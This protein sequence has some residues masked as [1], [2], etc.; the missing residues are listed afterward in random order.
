M[1]ASKRVASI[2]RAAELKRRVTPYLRVC[3]KIPTGFLLEKQYA[4]NRKRVLSVLG[5][6]E[7]NWRD[8]RWHMRNR[9]SDAET[10][11]GILNLTEG[12]RVAIDTVGA[13]YRWGVSPYY[14]SLMDGDD[15]NCPIR[16]Q[17]LPVM[18]E[19]TDADAAL[20]PMAEES[21]S[22]A[23]CVT[24]RYPD[25][26][27]INLTNRCA[28]FCRHCQRKRNIGCVDEA[29]PRKE[30]R[31]ALDYVRDNREIRDVLLTGGDPFT[32]D[33]G[34]LDWVLG[35]LDGIRHVE[36]KRIGTRTLCTLPM[37]TT[38]KLARMLGKHAPLYV[39]THFNHPK[40]VTRDAARAC[41]LLSREGVPLG[42]QAVLLK[43]V[44][45]DPYVMKK[46]C[47]ELLRIRVRPYYLYH[48]KN[49]PGAGKFRTSVSAG[50]RIISEMRGFTSGLAVP[51]F[52]INTP[53][54]LGKVALLPDGVAR[55]KGGKLILRTW[56]GRFVDYSV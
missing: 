44:N 56:E 15:A 33:D 7:R 20:D 29:K 46:L 54:G 53:G 34:E 32:L 21:S 27:I 8:W 10:L 28:M 48:C 24:R 37:R 36:I 2:R 25:R 12:E 47:Q 4:R 49:V 14:A 3:E 1:E 6:T 9:I 30:V 45:D 31:K 17:S 43:G 23:P 38:P 13:K 18:E 55:R 40:S 16:M 26:L 41:E 5:G 50:L 11:G 39:N 22:P 35:E 42:N 52:I 19:V 51:Q